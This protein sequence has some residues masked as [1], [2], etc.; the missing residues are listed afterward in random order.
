MELYVYS[1]LLTTEEVPENVVA[2][3]CVAVIDEA[4]ATVVEVVPCEL[5]TVGLPVKLVIALAL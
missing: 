3:D 5:A 2:L 4:S 1:P